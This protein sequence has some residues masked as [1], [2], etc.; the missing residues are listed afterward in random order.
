MTQ[1][2]CILSSPRHH[3]LRTLYDSNVYLLSVAGP[4]MLPVSSVV[5][6]AGCALWQN[7]SDRSEPMSL[8]EL[9]A[10]IG[11]TPSALS[12]HMRYLSDDYRSGKEGLGLTGM[13]RPARRA[14]LH[15]LPVAMPSRSSSIAASS[16]SSGAQ[17]THPRPSRPW[18]S[19]LRRCSRQSLQAVGLR[20]T[21]SRHW[22][23][24]YAMTAM[25]AMPWSTT[26]RPR[27]PAS[28]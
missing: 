21:P 6:F 12:A 3:H 23:T 18:S 16:G 1:R 8:E 17:D 20:S 10:R 7:R 27:H 4:L 15:S 11:K 24:Q 28:H 13:T 26:E 2:E 14:A 22:T 19:G 25:G 5:V 9:A